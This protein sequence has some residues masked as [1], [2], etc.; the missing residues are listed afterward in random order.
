MTTDTMDIRRII[1][2]TM[3]KLYASKFH[4][5]EEMDQFLERCKLP[6]THK[7][8]EITFTPVPI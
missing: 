4:N 1:K 2:Q 6:T 3:K 5:L 7:E 8:K